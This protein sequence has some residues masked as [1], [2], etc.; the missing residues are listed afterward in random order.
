ME[1]RHSGFLLHR[2]LELRPLPADI[3]AA[4]HGNL[5]QIFLGGRLLLVLPQFPGS[6]HHG[7]DGL[8]RHGSLPLRQHVGQLFVLPLRLARLRRHQNHGLVGIVQQILPDQALKIALVHCLLQEVKGLLV[9]QMHERIP[10]VQPAVHG[11]QAVHQPLGRGTVVRLPVTELVVIETGQQAL[12]V[13][14]LVRQTP[15]RTLDRDQKL[16]LLLLVGV[17]GDHG[18]IGL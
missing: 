15:Q 6:P 5:F 14:A 9:L 8:G 10:V 2:V 7:L 12:P 16:R 11:P 3:L 17:L 13:D 4:Q 1:H 18:K